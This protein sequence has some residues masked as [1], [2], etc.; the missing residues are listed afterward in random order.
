MGMYSLR[1]LTCNHLLS[2]DRYNHVVEEHLRF[3]N[4]YYVSQIG[5]VQRH[6]SLINALVERWYLDTHIFHLSVGEY[7]VT[8][9]DV[10]L[11]LGLPTNGVSLNLRLYRFCNS[12]RIQLRMIL[13]NGCFGTSVTTII[14]PYNPTVLSADHANPDKPITT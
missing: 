6:K 8:L 5:I 10:T 14:P 7:V 1:N 13:R 11:I 9:E 4:F 3:T 2:P 12:V